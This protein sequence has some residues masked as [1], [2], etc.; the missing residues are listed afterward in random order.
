MSSHVHSPL[1]PETI[2]THI[3]EADHRVANSLAIISGLVRLNARK[4]TF[5]DPRTFLMEIADRI[6]TIGTLHRLVAHSNS[7][8]VQF[9]KYLQ[10]ICEPMSGA[11]D[12]NASPFSI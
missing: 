8:R 7:G 10:E 12:P 2:S 9:S 6:D 4:G 3:R 5:A 1:L 11:L